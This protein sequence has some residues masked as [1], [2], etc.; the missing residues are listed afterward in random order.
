MLTEKPWQPYLVV[1]LVLA[2]VVSLCFGSLLA[3]ALTHFISK[4]NLVDR[5][6]LSFVMATLSF[7]GV[8]LLLIAQFLSHHDIRWKDA[9]GFSSSNWGISIGLGVLAIIITFGFTQWLGKIS[10][11]ALRWLS[12]LLQTK[13]IQPQPQEVV[14]QLQT[15]MPLGYTM[16]YGVM[17][18][19]LAP[20]AEEMLFRGILY[21]TL[22]QNGFRRSAL[23]LSSV[24]FALTHLN[25]MLIVPLTFLALV[26]ALLYEF[27][28]NLSAP[29]TAH[30]LFNALDFLL[31]LPAK[32]W[33]LLH[34]VLPPQMLEAMR[35]LVSF[36]TRPFSI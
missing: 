4:E 12:Q 26:L 15:A 16:V 22:K 7:Q 31:M 33:D 25:L 17:A 21:P 1:S 14:V 13:S 10:D 20:I 9:F 29:I 35:A 3:S 27:T 19:I 28:G 34:S 36:L 11:E 6:F 5:K 23:I 18:I 24:I 32:V 8:A 30:C 2:L